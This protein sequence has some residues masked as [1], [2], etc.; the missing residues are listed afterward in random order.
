MSQYLNEIAL[1]DTIKVRGPFGK[2]TY[3][4]EGNF[5][6]QT[7]IKPLEFAERKYTKVG[8]LAGGTGITPIYQILQAANRN[9][10]ITEF[11]LVFGNKTSEDILLRKELSEMAESGNFKFTLHFLIDKDES[12]WKGLTGYVTKDLAKSYLPAAS[13]DTLIL[14]CGPPIMCEKAKDIFKE[15]SHSEENIFKF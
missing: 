13:S 10:D 8:M 4:G 1:Q 2:L 11:T 9:K 15:L 12:E 3:L 6:F 14:M 5:K 7:K